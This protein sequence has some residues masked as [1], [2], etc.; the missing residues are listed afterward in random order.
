MFIIS[1]CFISDGTN[2]KFRFVEDGGDC[3]S[4]NHYRGGFYTFR[5]YPHNNQGR[6]FVAVND[7]DGRHRGI[8]FAAL[9][10]DCALCCDNCDNAYNKERN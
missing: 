2:D 10:K 3:V 9:A 7:A 1:Q 5:L 4:L 8:A 6:V